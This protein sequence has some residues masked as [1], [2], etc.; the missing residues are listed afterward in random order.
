[1]KSTSGIARNKKSIAERVVL[2]YLTLLEFVNE[3]SRL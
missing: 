1:M 2:L 3:T